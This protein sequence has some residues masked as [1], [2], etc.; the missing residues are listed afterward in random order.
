MG[1]RKEGGRE[2]GREGGIGGKAGEVGGRRKAENCSY[3]W[4]KCTVLRMTFL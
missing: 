3:P 2:G 1:G 4:Q